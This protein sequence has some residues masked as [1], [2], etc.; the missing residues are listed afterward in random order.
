MTISRVLRIH[1]DYHYR[2]SSIKN[3]K[4]L[5]NNSVMMI[6]IFLK[7]VEKALYLG[8]NL[9]FLDEVGFLWKILII[10]LGGKL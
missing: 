1:L 2:K 8:L 9:I 4:L 6:Y 5:E 7:I 3:S 10:I